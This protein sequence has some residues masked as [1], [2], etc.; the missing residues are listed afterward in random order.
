MY[1][2]LERGSSG[3]IFEDRG[4]VLILMTRFESPLAGKEKE[5]QSPPPFSFLSL[6]SFFLLSTHRTLAHPIPFF[7]T[8]SIHYWNIPFL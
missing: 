4:G 8:L 5:L 6:F 2:Y 3:A 7:I 1:D